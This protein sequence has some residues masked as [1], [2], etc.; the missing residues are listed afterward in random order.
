MLHM[1][2]TVGMVSQDSL[3]S[4]CIGAGSEDFKTLKEAQFFARM[5][6]PEFTGE[7]D[8]LVITH[9]VHGP[10]VETLR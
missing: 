2:Y 6:L 5:V 8:Q 4:E 3:D 7:Y 9:G 10:I 1:T